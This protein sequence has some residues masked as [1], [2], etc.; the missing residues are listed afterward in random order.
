M[1]HSA[2]C[3]GAKVLT[4]PWPLLPFVISLSACS[5]FLEDPPL[6]DAEQDGQVPVEEDAVPPFVPP[7]P[8]DTRLVRERD[9][10]VDRQ[11]RD[12]SV[13]DQGVMDARTPSDQSLPS[14]DADAS[15][16][17]QAT[18]LDLSASEMGR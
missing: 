16:E 4:L 15:N 18:L 1:H 14:S 7:P 6:F 2:P 5:L 9:Q 8:L 12:R 11:I 17:D 3:R 13:V 10:R